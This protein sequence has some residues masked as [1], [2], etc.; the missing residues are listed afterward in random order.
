[1]ENSFLS[2]LAGWLAGAVSFGVVA[3]SHA[4]GPAAGWALVGALY[5]TPFILFVW[6]TCLWPLYKF[7]PAHSFAWRPLVCVPA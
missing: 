1:M 6:L 5:S 2:A 7:V 3:A 4:G